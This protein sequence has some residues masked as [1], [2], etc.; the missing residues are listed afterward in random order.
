MGINEMAG[1]ARLSNLPLTSEGSDKILPALLS[2]RKA[3]GKA[4]KNAE[5]P[6]IGSVYADYTRCMETVEPPLLDVGIII[7]FFP[8][9]YVKEGLV[10]VLCRLTHAESGQFR[11][12][13]LSAATTG[14]AWDVGSATT[15]LK[16][17]TVSAL[18]GL[19]TED[20][21]GARATNGVRNNAGTG[22]SDRNATR[23]PSAKSDASK[24]PATDN[25]RKLITDLAKEKGVEVN[26]EVFSDTKR[27]SAY[28]DEL[29]AIRNPVTITE[30]KDGAVVAQTT[31]GE[32]ESP[33]SDAAAEPTVAADP[34]KAEAPTAEAPKEA[35][36][37]VEPSKTFTALKAKWKSA[38]KSESDA[39]SRATW[40]KGQDKAGKFNPG[41]A[42]KLIADCCTFN[43]A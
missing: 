39:Q 11:Q 4:V 24:K 20:D 14:D 40:V 3:I 21:D 42:E 28:I 25:Q 2:A 13:V 38:P 30:V 6:D 22:S 15:Y 18:T 23:G 41:E 43:K 1:A 31:N 33:K 27:A 19:K 8:Q 17:Y 26:E 16:R 29:K 32:V 12:A 9:S 7:E 5:N 37:E 10:E 34:V 36:A 35:V